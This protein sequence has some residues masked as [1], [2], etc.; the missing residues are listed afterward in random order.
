[1]AWVKGGHV[2]NLNLDNN[3]KQTFGKYHA[4]GKGEEMES[5]MSDGVE[6]KQEKDF[7]VVKVYLNQPL[8]P[9]G[10]TVF[11]IKFTT[12]WDNGSSQRSRFKKIPSYGQFQYDGVHWYPRI[13]VY[14]RKFGWDTDQH[15]GKEFYGDF[16]AFNVKLNFASNFVVEG[17]GTL[18]NE[19][20]V[21]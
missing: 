19:P 18:L 3:Y 7:S 14:D 9:G 5:I 21:M 15:L 8:L 4:A 20:E 2:E 16:G 6:L 13:C 12:Y 17:T 11:N 10:N 1:Q